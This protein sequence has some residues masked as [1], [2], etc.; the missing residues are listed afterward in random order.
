M[1]VVRIPTENR[2]LEEAGAITAF[3]A[4]HGIDYEQW[5]PDRPGRRG[6]H[7]G[8]AARGLWSGNREAES[9]RWLPHG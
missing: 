2:V 6:R 1:A 3:L 9:A 5:A 4:A 8:H 7:G